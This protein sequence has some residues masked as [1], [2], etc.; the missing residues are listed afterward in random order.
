[1]ITVRLTA[2][3][4]SGSTRLR[5]RDFGRG[6]PEG[7]LKHGTGLSNTAARLEQLYGS[8]HKLEFENCQDGGLAVT[9][10]VPYRT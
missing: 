8:H 9:V 6:M 1:V 3:F 5:I 10:A 4:D 2:E 7:S